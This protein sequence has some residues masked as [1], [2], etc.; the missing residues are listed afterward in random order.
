MDTGMT[1]DTSRLRSA[2]IYV[3]TNTDKQLPDV[4]NRAALTT[5]IGGKGVK[6]AMQRTPKADKTKIKTLPARLIVRVVIK[7]LRAKGVTIPQG[8]A[9]VQFIAQAVK[10]EIKRRAAASGY[11]AYVG[12][13]KAAMAFGGRGVGKRAANAKGYAT[14]GYGKRATVGDLVAEMVNAAPVASKIGTAPLQAALNDQARDMI[15]HTNEKL[16]KIFDQAN[17]R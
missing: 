15:Q 11:T 10:K 2:I 16:Q 5:I 14:R 17:R 13:N 6:G 4:V 3:V 7:K 12:W 1:I 9:G 8:K